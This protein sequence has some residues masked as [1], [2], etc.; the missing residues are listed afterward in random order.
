MKL[1]PAV[2]EDGQGTHKRNWF[3]YMM[4]LFS[5]SCVIDL[6][7]CFEALGYVEGFMDFYLENGEPYF[8]TSFGIYINLWDAVAHYILY[9]TIIYK[10]DNKQDYRSFGIYWLGSMLAGMF[11]L[12]IGAFVGSYGSQLH[13]AIILNIPYIILP[14]CALVY[15]L[16]LPRHEVY[17][18]VPEHPPAES[19]S[20]SIAGLDMIILIGLITSSVFGFI[21]GLS[22]LGSPLPLIVQYVME[23]EPYIKDPT[24][25][26]EMHCLFNFIYCVPGQVMLA[27]AFAKGGQKW[28]EDLSVWLSGATAQGV[29]FHSLA[30]LSTR[31]PQE[32]RITNNIEIFIFMNALSVVVPHLAMFRIRSSGQK[33]W[34]QS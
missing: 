11:V 18:P 5:W 7:L 27:Y 25:F 20:K 8:T 22:A 16:Q 6:I 29:F 30:A 13:P 32:F 24:R 28:A 26:A 2:Y 15:L 3:Y 10:Y 14:F 34:K 23:Y 12:V 9:L 33:H 21:R 4:C 19:R 31:T 17:Q 1:L